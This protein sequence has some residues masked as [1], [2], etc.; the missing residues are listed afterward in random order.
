[1]YVNITLFSTQQSISFYTTQTNTFHPHTSLSTI[2]HLV[3]SELD[4]SQATNVGPG[5]L[6]NYSPIKAHNL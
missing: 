3:H 6:Q 5:I 2:A 4:H 1:M